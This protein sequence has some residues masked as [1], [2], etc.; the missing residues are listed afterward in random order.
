MENQYYPEPTKRENFELYSKD[1]QN[2]II[3]AEIE[4]E[5]MSENSGLSE[6]IG[7]Q[8]VEHL[9]KIKD[10]Y[11]QK[12][13]SDKPTVQEGS[14]V[15]GSAIT[16]IDLAYYGQCHSLETINRA[17]MSV[18]NSDNFEENHPLLDKESVT[19]TDDTDEGEI[20]V[21]INVHRDEK[22][23]EEAVIVELNTFSDEISE[24]IDEIEKDDQSR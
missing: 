4:S 5:L 11:Y 2:R 15:S 12:S 1:E 8:A 6:L 14:K 19:I 22:D 21:S 13:D 9:Q 23:I 20:I 17:V 24:K 7:K 3:D 16:R 10:T 18:I